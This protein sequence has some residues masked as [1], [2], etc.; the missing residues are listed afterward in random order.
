MI[1]AEHKLVLIFEIKPVY[2]TLQQSLRNSSR[3]YPTLPTTVTL[4][5]LSLA[6]VAL[7]V[8]LANGWRH[9]RD[10]TNTFRTRVS[11]IFGDDTMY[12]LGC[13]SIARPSVHF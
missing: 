3:G 13:L 8:L 9:C 7:E 4:S 5:G 12:S 1:D 6:L 11:E 10:D 2:L